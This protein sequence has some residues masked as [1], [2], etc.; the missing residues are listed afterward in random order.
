[1]KSIA[2]VL[3]IAIAIVSSPRLFAQGHPAKSSA[4]FRA[5]VAKE[6]ASHGYGKKLYERCDGFQRM[7][8]HRVGARLGLYASTAPFLGNGRMLKTSITENTA[9]VDAIPVDQNETSIAI[10]RT[11]PK[12]VIAGSNLLSMDNLTA[13]AYVSTN[14]GLSWNTTLLPTPDYFG[15]QPYGDPS[16]VCSADGMFY[17]A[18]LLINFSDTTDVS[19]LMVAH[20]QDGQHWT[21]GNPVLGMGPI[22]SSRFLFQDKENITV[23]RDPS[24]PYY[25]RLYIAWNEYFDRNGDSSHAMIAWS[26]DRGQS[27]SKQ[28]SL[29]TDGGLFTLLRTG[30]HGTLFHA[31][32]TDSGLTETYG[33]H[34]LLVSHDGGATFIER[35]VAPFDNFP[36]NSINYPGLK[37]FNGFRSFPYVAFD[38]DPSTNKL[39][40]V[41]GSYNNNLNAASLLAITSTDE[42]ADWTPPIVLG[43]PRKQNR[44]HFQAWVSFDPVLQQPR[45]TFL[46]SEDDP[47]SNNLIRASRVDWSTLDAPKNLDQSLFDP[48]DIPFT[49]YPFI[50]D[51]IGSDAFGGTFAAAWTGKNPIGTDGDI[52]AYVSTDSF[53][54]PVGGPIHAPTFSVSEPMPNPVF[55]DQAKI[56]VQADGPVDLHVELF[57]I[58]GATALST[59]ATCN[60]EAQIVLDVH[61]LPAGIYRIV[62]SNSSQSMEENMIILR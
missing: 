41:Y 48:R 43:D 22:D 28:E 45:V 24:S 4:A 37:G 55:G 1:M 47:D 14:A 7:I 34:L 32:S 46:S 20:S 59:S 23:D 60:S 44:D 42:G 13:P 54:A 50:G 29:P 21:L 2:L 26:D 27:W 35:S 51:Y 62:I 15:A 9:D 40:L 18:F 25:G 30:A 3:F 39:Y 8:D 31:S 5:E 52:F 36:I 12:L 49:G 33:H 11:N 56:S 58:R 6:L 16:I 38:V 19:D 61:A 53:R 57:D 10:S 17:Y